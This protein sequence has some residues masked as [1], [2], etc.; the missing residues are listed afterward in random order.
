MVKAALREAIALGTVDRLDGCV[1]DGR[2]ELRRAET[3]CRAQDT[4]L[5]GE[6]F[7]AGTRQ[8]AAR[9]PALITRRAP[10]PDR[11]TRLPRRERA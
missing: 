9:G 3:C 4:I 11:A 7:G 2:A 1:H 10:S 6:L 5:R 8:A